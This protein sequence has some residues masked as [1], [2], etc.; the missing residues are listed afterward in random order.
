MARR[1]HRAVQLQI[2]FPAQAQLLS[3]DDLRRALARRGC[4]RLTTIHF[5]KNRGRIISLSKDG[6]TLHIHACFQEANED[7]LKAVVT[8]LNAGRN[9]YA[10]R[11]SIRAMRDFFEAHASKYVS[12]QGEEEDTRIVRIVQR[13]PCV[14]TAAQRAFL[15][16]AYARFNTACFQSKLPPTVRIRMSD[17]MRSRLGHVRYHTTTSGE[18]LVLE[19][20]L[21]VHLFLPGNEEVLLDT[22]LHE[23]THIEAWLLHAERGHGRAWKDIAHRVGCEATACSTQ[24]IRRRRR[25]AAVTE[26]PDR[27]HLPALPRVQEHSAA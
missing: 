6:R 14:G 12:L 15:R 2:D 21:N 4:R 26:V 27:S 24:P 11:E 3:A 17:R 13:L 7:A 8:F 18:R 25:G 22:L 1:P 19:L 16:D 23:M 9:S 20:A 10:Y 5:K